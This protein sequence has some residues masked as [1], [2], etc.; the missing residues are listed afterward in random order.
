[1]TEFFEMYLENII[2]KLDEALNFAIK[3]DDT[4]AEHRIFRALEALQGR[5]A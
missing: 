3:V 2:N 5:E 4:E 1:M